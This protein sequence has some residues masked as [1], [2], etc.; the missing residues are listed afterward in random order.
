MNSS[1]TF[2]DNFVGAV[3][4][5]HELVHLILKGIQEKRKEHFL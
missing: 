4:M 2:Y 3:Y 1:V 5:L